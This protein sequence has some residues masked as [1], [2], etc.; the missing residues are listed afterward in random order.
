VQRLLAVAFP[1]QGRLAPVC[2]LLA[3]G[4]GLPGDLSMLD[5]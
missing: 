5:A 3:A 1:A 4:C 2:E